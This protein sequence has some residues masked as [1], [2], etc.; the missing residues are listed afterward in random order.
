MRARLRRLAKMSRPSIAEMQEQWSRAAARHLSD[1]E[2]WLVRDA[3]SALKPAYCRD[4]YGTFI[5]LIEL[6]LMS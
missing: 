3:L 1:E 2:L 4:R 6:V 5:P